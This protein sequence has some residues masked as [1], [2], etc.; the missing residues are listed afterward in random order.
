MRHTFTFSCVAALVSVLP[1]VAADPLFSL[2][3]GVVAPGGGTSTGGA[4]SVTGTVGETCAGSPLAYGAKFDLASGFWA[5]RPA[6]MWPEAEILQITP[7]SAGGY[8]ATMIWAP[9]RSGWRLEYSFGLSEWN[10]LL[11]S[12]TAEPVTTLNFS[13]P[14]P[15]PPLTALRL[16]RNAN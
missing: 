16:K 6:V 11:S 4:F 15:V 10:P 5:G 2:Q 9:S 3:R 1:A 8:S 12:T 14:G 13:S 7:L